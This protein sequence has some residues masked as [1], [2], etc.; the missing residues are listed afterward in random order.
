M[1]DSYIFYYM[2]SAPVQRKGHLPSEKN[3]KNVGKCC[4]KNVVMF[5]SQAWC[6]A[7]LSKPTR[8][9][10]YVMVCLIGEYGYP[11]LS[12]SAC[13]FDNFLNTLAWLKTHWKTWNSW[14]KSKE[15]V[16]TWGTCCVYV[17]L[18]WMTSQAPLCRAGLTRRTRTRLWRQ[19]HRH[20]HRHQHRLPNLLPLKQSKCCWHL[21]ETSLTHA[22]RCY[23]N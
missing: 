1:Q 3:N 19:N 6:I 13:C 18:A 11:G 22:N 5:Q 2:V 16:Y 21:N 8:W 15:R 23:S 7:C 17:Q 4:I 10:I 12:I 20:Q 14:R 9:L